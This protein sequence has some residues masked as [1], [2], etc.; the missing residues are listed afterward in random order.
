MKSQASG[1]AHGR[2][3]S[4]GSHLL[5]QQGNGC[6]SENTA[7][8]QWDNCYWFY[9]LCVQVLQWWRAVQ[10]LKKTDGKMSLVQTAAYTWVLT[11]ADQTANLHFFLL[12][13]LAADF[14]ILLLWLVSLWLWLG[15]IFPK[16]VKL[17]WAGKAAMLFMSPWGSCH[18]QGLTEIPLPSDSALQQWW[19]E[20]E[21]Q[22]QCP[23]SC[24]F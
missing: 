14:Q 5:E 7:A 3:H 13:N 23:M 15:P 9:M 20:V 21:Q 18:N 2:I 1:A 8:G 12:F 19:A 16:P 4:Q 24:N 11:Q 17:L 6:I 22:W 10:N